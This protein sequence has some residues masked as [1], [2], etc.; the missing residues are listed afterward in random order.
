MQAA[1]YGTYYVGKF[2][3]SQS[4]KT[5]N[6]PHAAGWTG[7]DFLLDPYT[8][9]YTNS[10]FQRNRELP[11][12]HQGRYST[13]VIAEKT[14]AFLDDALKS[15]KQDKKPFFLTTAPIAPHGT[16]CPPDIREAPIAAERHRGLFADVIVPRTMNFNPKEVSGAQ[17]VANLARQNDSNVEWN[18]EYYRQRLRALQSVDEMVDGLVRRLDN[19]GVL[20]NTYIFFSTD[21]GF[22]IGQHRMQPGKQ[23]PYEEDLRVPMIVRGPGLTKGAKTAILTSHVDLAP[24]FLALAEGRVLADYTLDGQV[25]PFTQPEDKERQAPSD[26]IDWTAQSQEQVNV[27]HWGIHIPEGKYGTELYDQNTYKAV[28]IVSPGINIQYT[29]W[30]TGEKELYDLDVRL[31][32]LVVI[33]MSNVANSLSDGSIP[34]EK[35]RLGKCRRCEPYR[36]ADCSRASSCSS[37]GR[38][39]NSRWRPTGPFDDRCPHH[40][41]R[42]CAFAASQRLQRSSVYAPMEV[43]FSNCSSPQPLA[44]YGCGIRQFFPAKPQQ[45]GL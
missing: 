22:H 18:D 42:G 13:D 39:S 28:R 12:S 15:L 25:M 9:C 14:F 32:P 11:A 4:L 16:V 34:N 8:Y 44:G 20:Q 27:E 31:T 10:T 24:T 17:W 38:I 33:L 6:K 26:W 23:S 29:V 36:N 21:N 35:P 45:S 3:N 5:Y 1:G 30:C 43:L 19:A 37:P 40:L 41:A 7:S 2:M